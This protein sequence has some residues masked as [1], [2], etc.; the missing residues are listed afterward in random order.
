MELLVS[1]DKLGVDAVTRQ[2]STVID[3][4]P[5]DLMLD[6]ISA[7]SDVGLT[8]LDVL[9]SKVSRRVAPLADPG[10]RRPGIRPL[11]RWRSHD[12]PINQ[13]I[14]SLTKSTKPSGIERVQAGT[15]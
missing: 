5:L 8:D 12:F 7:T 15:R 3:Q 4:C 6:I 11:S 13:S 14:Y 2:C 10:G 9:E 1:S